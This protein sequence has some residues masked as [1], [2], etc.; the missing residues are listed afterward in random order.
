MSTVVAVLTTKDGQGSSTLALS[1][2]WAAAA[3]ARTMLID[4]DMSGTG[5]IADLIALDIESQG[6][7]GLFGTQAITAEMLETQAIHAPSRAH[8]RVVPGLQGFCGPSVAE[9]LPRLAHAFSSLTDELVIIDLGAPLAHPGLD[10][11][12]RVGEIICS[13]ANRVLVVSQ[14]GPSRLTKTIQI[15]MQAQLPRAELIVCETRRGQMRDQIQRTV[16]HHLPSVRLSGFVAWD[17]RRAIKAEDAAVPLPGDEVLR[18]LQLL[19]HARRG[20]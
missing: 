9:L 6:V 12:R 11:P 5:N 1:I 18:N 7:G 8:L 16:A 10:S 20:R 4:A 14:D 15:L 3:R 13:V 17:E 19:Q 2:A